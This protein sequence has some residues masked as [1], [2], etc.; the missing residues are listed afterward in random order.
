MPEQSKDNMSL[1]SICLLFGSKH[2]AL[3]KK[4]SEFST[5]SDHILLIYNKQDEDI[6]DRAK[7]MLSE[8]K[9]AGR[10][11]SKNTEFIRLC[12]RIAFDLKPGHP[13]P[14][15][16]GTFEYELF[17]LNLERLLKKAKKYDLFLQQL[18]KET[19]QEEKGKSP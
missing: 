1:D 15:K 12:S 19:A 6:S 17:G 14:V 7:K 16:D 13:A 5:D 4:I 18:N 8:G 11:F 2:V 3:I 9:I 10:L